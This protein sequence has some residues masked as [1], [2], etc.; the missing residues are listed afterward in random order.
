MKPTTLTIQKNSTPISTILLAGLVAGILDGSAA[1]IQFMINSG[2]KSP[3]IVFK[4]ISS[5]LLGK[6]ALAGGTGM[7]IL[8]ILLHMLIATIFAAIFFILYRNINWISKNIFVS[9]IIYGVLVWI[10]MNRV[11]V[12]LSRIPR[13]KSFDLTKAIT[14][15]LIL[16]F[17]IGIPIALI[18]HKRMKSV[19]RES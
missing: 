18:V 16:I 15:A 4:Y 17:C 8:G 3:A 7:V 6:E 14:A 9:G 2:G 12:P 10:A 19:R 11:V 1:S 13:P 5:A